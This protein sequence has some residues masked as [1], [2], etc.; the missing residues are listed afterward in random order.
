MAWGGSWLLL[1]TARDGPWLVAALAEFTPARP[2][3]EKKG[4]ADA[5][6]KFA[7]NAELPPTLGESSCP[8][9]LEA[10]QAL[11]L[12]VAAARSPDAVLQADGASLGMTDGVALAPRLA[13]PT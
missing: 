10:L 4:C 2:N 5:P 9:Q 12:S 1:A 3:G 7:G 11:A 6:A 8:M 13:G